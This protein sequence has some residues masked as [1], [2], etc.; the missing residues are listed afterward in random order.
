MTRLQS[1]VMGLVIAFGLG[2]LVTLWGLEAEYRDKVAAARRASLDCDARQM[3]ASPRPQ[4][5]VAS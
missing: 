1:I 3:L 2:V 4:S 5:G